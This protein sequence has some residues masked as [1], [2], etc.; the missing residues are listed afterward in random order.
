LRAQTQEDT[1]T[2]DGSEEYYKQKLREVVIWDAIALH[3]NES[4]LPHY[5]LHTASVCQRGIEV[6]FK[7]EN[8]PAL[9]MDVA[10]AVL[11]VY[12]RMQL[13]VH[14]KAAMCKLAREKPDTTY[15]NFV[16]FV[17]Q[18]YVEG[19]TL[20]ASRMDRFAEMVFNH[21]FEAMEQDAEGAEQKQ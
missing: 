20:D 1:A 21:P 16:G 13:S 14:G 6:D 19:F 17:A 7:G 4:V 2:P 11:E 12:P 8:L 9:P 5:P 10:K 18:R 15:D 3:T